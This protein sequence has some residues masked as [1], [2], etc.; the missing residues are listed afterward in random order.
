LGGRF[1]RDRIGSGRLA[2]QPERGFRLLT[3]QLATLLACAR[4]RQAT[5]CVYKHF[6]A[7]AILGGTPQLRKYLKVSAFVLG[8]WLAGIEKPPVD[9]FL[10]AVDIIVDSE[11]ENLRRKS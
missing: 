1:I 6:S 3:D 4:P 8:V 10:K 11:V 9:V 5:T 7:R 2:A